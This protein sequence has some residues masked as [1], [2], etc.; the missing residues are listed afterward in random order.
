VRRL[1]R[2]LI[3]SLMALFFLFLP[4]LSCAQEEYSR[5]EVGGEY[6]AFRGASDLDNDVRFHAGLGARFAWNLNR[7]LA[8]EAQLD[9]APGPMFTNLKLQGGSALSAVFGARAKILQSRRFA[10]FGLLRPGL[11]HFSAVGHGDAPFA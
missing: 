3:L 1:S 6:A 2:F 4:P 11:L 5:F 8:L 10:V 7:R 9:G